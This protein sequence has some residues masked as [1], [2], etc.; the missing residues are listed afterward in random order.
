MKKLMIM[1]SLFFCLL[2]N[3]LN[4]EQITNSA[5]LSQPQLEQIL[6]PIALY[7]D[8]L[9]T[10]ILIAATYPLEVIEA[11]RWLSLNAKLGQ[12]QILQQAQEK[13]WAPSI[14]ALLPFPSL[15]KKLSHDLDWTRQLGD[16]FLQSEALVLSSIQTLRVS[17]DKA[18]NLDKMT[19]MN[20]RHQDDYI[21]IQPIQKEIIYVPYYD[22]RVVYGSWRWRRYP[23]I[24]WPHYSH[25]HYQSHH[26]PFYWH[27][28]VHISS[29]L[30]FGNFHWQNHH[31]VISHRHNSHYYG[32]HHSHHKKYHKKHRKSHYNSLNRRNVDYQGGKYRSVKRW[33][34]Q[35]RHR[36]GVAYSNERLRKR[37]QHNRLANK[38]HII[39]K[40]SKF[41]SSRHDKKH[42]KSGLVRSTKTR[43]NI[44]D[45]SRYKKHNQIQHKLAK[46]KN[47]PGDKY[48]NTGGNNQAKHRNS[49]RDK[50]KYHRK[51]N[52]HTKKQLAK[53]AYRREQPLKAKVRPRHVNNNADKQRH[54]QAK[55]RAS[56]QQKQA[57]KRVSR[58]SY[59]LNRSKAHNRHQ[60]SVA[61]KINNRSRHY[62]RSGKVRRHDIE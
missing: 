14:M 61:R 46:K 48:Q 7:P 40:K 36:K 17:A 6:A 47:S 4:A 15:L 8:S 62:K 2:A 9:L 27:T 13:D 23:P 57:A 26:G 22:T 21:I 49:N 58:S 51:I 45:A 37:Y 31:V 34:H 52:D 50:L 12:E 19:N 41:S 24:Y 38:P 28:G 56:D 20:V 55:F 43:N 10:H 30:L 35:P 54:Q 11:E 44:A 18:G 53:R 42:L 60:K 59:K 5:E 25:H 1:I 32:R 3:N 33:Q 29:G 39:E 16:A